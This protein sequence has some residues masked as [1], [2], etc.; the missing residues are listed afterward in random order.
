MAEILLA[1]D[2]RIVRNRYVQLF[3]GE[4]YTVRA[5]RDGAAAL[6]AFSDKRP[7]MVVL[8]LDMPNLSGYRVCEKIRETDALV[9]VV[10]L[11]AGDTEAN[12]VRSLSLGADCFC[13]KM[14]S[15]SV[16]L[17][18]VRRAMERSRE[19]ASE[20]AAGRGGLPA[21]V[22]LG[23]I[24]LDADTLVVTDGRS[25]AERLTRGEFDVFAS[26]YEADGRSLSAEEVLSAMLE[27][28]TPCDIAMLYQHISN[29]RRKLGP[30]GGLLVHQRR[31]GYRILK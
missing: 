28:G 21:V 1:E 12:E 29:L 6:E 31:V 3:Q 5:V 2:D 16:L 25:H 26:L 11:T 9:P 4:G 22:K 19:I 8:D 7:D 10:I 27:R 13:S 24:T 23:K 18:R 14:A 17:S 30:A 15:P 20:T